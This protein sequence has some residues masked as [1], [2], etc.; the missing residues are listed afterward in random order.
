MSDEAYGLRHINYDYDAELQATV[1]AFT[2]NAEAV[3]RCGE[4]LHGGRPA[5]YC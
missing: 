5:F 1:A 3:H 4:L 2:V